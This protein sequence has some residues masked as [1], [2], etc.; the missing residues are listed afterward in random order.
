MEK[1]LVGK[2]SHYFDK[3]NVAVVELEDKLKAGDK[4]VIESGDG[5]ES[6]TQ[7][8]KSMQVEHET[9]DK[10]KKGDSV[11]MKTDQP[12]KENWKVYKEE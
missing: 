4:I 8:V 9:I 6:F 11:G 1:K 10:A 2:I 5:S 3:I 7:E 12:A